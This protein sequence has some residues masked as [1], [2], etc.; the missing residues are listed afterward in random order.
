M[1]TPP[2]APTTPRVTD[3]ATIRAARAMAASLRACADDPP[4]APA[5]EA[6]H[7]R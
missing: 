4:A 7:G 6:T 1:D 5:P 2:P 3:L